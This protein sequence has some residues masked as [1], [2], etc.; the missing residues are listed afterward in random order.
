MFFHVVSPEKAGLGHPGVEES[1]QY[2]KR[3]RRET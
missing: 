1:S 2:K 3:Y